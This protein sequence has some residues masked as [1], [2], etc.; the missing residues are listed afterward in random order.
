VYLWTEREDRLPK[1]GREKPR[2]T[3]TTPASYPLNDDGQLVTPTAAKY[4]V[5]EWVGGNEECQPRKVTRGP[6][7]EWQ[8]SAL[9]ECREENTLLRKGPALDGIPP[10]EESEKVMPS[11]ASSSDRARLEQLGTPQEV[12]EFY[13]IIHGIGY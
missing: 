13:F 5:Y 1:Q 9:N 7:D 4:K 6:V 10:G 3:A 8:C 11:Y 2:S 12:D